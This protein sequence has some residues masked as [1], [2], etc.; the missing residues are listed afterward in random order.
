MPVTVGPERLFLDANVLFSAAYSERSIVRRVWS[1]GPELVVLLTSDYAIDESR[2]NLPDHAVAELAVVLQAV[3]IVPTPAQ[4]HWIDFPEIVLP[5]KDRPIF[6]AAIAAQ[7]THLI[8]GDRKHFGRYF[9]QR[10]GTLLV[11]SPDM[12]RPAPEIDRSDD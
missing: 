11:M 10:I 6:Q 8:T 3:Q 4:Q 7:A 5:A 1:F 9:E 12:Y 2:R